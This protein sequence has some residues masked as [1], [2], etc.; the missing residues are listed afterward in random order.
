MEEKLNKEQSQLTWIGTCPDCGGHLPEGPH[1]GLAINATCKDCGA[2]FWIAP[3]FT[4]ISR[5]LSPGKRLVEGDARMK[6]KRIYWFSAGDRPIGIVVG[7]D[8]ITGARRGYINT[9]S[10]LNEASDIQ[11][12]AETGTPID[13]NMLNEIVY[14]LRG[15]LK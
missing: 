13:P 10:G 9:V 3:P 12:I 5:R 2:V 6:I 11:H 1:G 4:F 15:G 8:E 14:Y 7:E